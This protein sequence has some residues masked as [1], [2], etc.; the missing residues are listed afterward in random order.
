MLS[1]CFENVIETLNVDPAM[2]FS[3]GK[4]R[5]GHALR[6]S[7]VAQSGMT[8]HSGC[9][10]GRARSAEE[11][12]RGERRGGLSS[13]RIDHPRGRDHPHAARAAAEDLIADGTNGYLQ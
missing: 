1:E 13:L 6:A 7:A 10:R 5:V 9:Q 11:I 8:R 12:R 2:E 3:D 4:L